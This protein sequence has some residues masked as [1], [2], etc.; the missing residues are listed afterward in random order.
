MTIEQLR[1]HYEKHLERL[2]AISKYLSDELET[3][4]DWNDDVPLEELV[5]D[6]GAFTGL[7]LGAFRVF[8]RSL[9]SEIDHTE[10]SLREYAANGSA[11][12]GRA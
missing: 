6:C 12:E 7:D 2:R 10:C 11:A 3:F 1:A 8:A 9:T 4:A 5:K